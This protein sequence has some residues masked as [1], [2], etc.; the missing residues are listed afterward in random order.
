MLLLVLG[1]NMLVTFLGWEG[2]GV[3]SYLLVG[4][5]FDSTHN[6]LAAIKA[7]IVNRIGDV[8]FLLAMFRTGR[9]SQL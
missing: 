8:G 5:W 6:S 2:V 1:E 4:Y 9:Q 7:F 3:C